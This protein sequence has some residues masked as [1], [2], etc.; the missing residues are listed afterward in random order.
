VVE[1]VRAAFA[2]ERRV[3]QGYIAC[4]VLRHLPDRAPLYLVAVKA[5]RIGDDQ[6]LV[7]RLVDAIELPG[8]FIVVTLAGKYKGFKKPLA[9]V[10]DAHVY[11]R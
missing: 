3:K 11:T 9:Q 2:A 7:N 4:K 8:R 1:R 6:K 10:P 5:T